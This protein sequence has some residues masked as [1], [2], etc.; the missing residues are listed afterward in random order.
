MGWFHCMYAAHTVLESESDL[1]I[2]SIAKILGV[3][4]QKD[5]REVTYYFNKG[6]TLEDVVNCI[7]DMT[8]KSEENG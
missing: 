8:K 3:L 1:N 5:C 6:G 4:N 2:D 7:I